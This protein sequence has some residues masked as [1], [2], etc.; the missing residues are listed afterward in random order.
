MRDPFIFADTRDQTYYLFGTTSVC[1]GAA[2]IDPYFE[3]WSSKDLINFE[4]PFAAFVPP[5]GYWGIRDYWAPE[6][7]QYKGSYYMLASF[8]GAIGQH[9]G[10]A[11]VKASHPAGP[12]LPHSPQMVTPPN[13]EALD[14]TLFVDKAGTPWLVYCKEWTSIFYG[15][16]E[17]VALTED[18]KEALPK[19]KV[20]LVDTEID[21]LP[22][23]RHMYDPRVEKRGYLTDAPF[24]HQNPDGS[25]LM[26]WSS[27]TIPGWQQSGQ[28]GYAIA[29]V[30]AESGTMTG[31]WRHLP[32]LL[33]D[34]N[35]GHPS[36]FKDFS[37]NLR[38]VCHCNDTKHGFEYPVLYAIQQKPD[39]LSIL[40]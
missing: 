6:V 31:T 35:A 17:A 33:L 38:L 7:H 8:K 39:G 15:K 3:V 21:T 20:T 26:L 13:E 22:W 1:N 12:Y 19:T 25:L 30:L 23:I 34:E 32:Q 16:I 11:I 2:D 18:L 36:L 14:G 40:L 27:Y 5:P 4:G 9:R 28:G 29:Q 10:T 24:L 37:G